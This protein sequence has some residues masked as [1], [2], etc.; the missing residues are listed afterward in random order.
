MKPSSSTTAEIPA[1]LHDLVTEFSSR[2]GDVLGDALVSVILYGHTVKGGADAEQSPVN[3]MLVLADASATV[4]DQ[5]ARLVQK[6]ARKFG[7]SA[8]VV[9]E[10]ELQ[11]STDVFPVKFLDMQ[12]AH[13]VVRGKN[14]LDDLLFDAENIRLRCEQEARNT[15][16]RLRHLYLHRANQAKQLQSILAT[17]F[18]QFLT[19]L[20]AFLFLIDGT[21]RKRESE[22]AADAKRALK[23]ESDV[24]QSLLDLA[25]SKQKFPISQLDLLLSEFIDAAHRAAELID[26]YEPWS[27]ETD[28]N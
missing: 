13:V 22:I 19:T 4:L 10:L 17:S 7:L 25:G 12:H 9:T 5:I 11:Q 18:H 3:V 21:L 27:R 14:V 2:L 24:L 20:N 1:A 16:L 28:A 23:L 15:L 26:C 6:A 8:M